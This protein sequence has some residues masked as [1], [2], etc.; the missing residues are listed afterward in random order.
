LAA[1]AAFAGVQGLAA[2]PALA[3]SVQPTIAEELAAPTAVID[4]AQQLADDG[5]LVRAYETLGDLLAGSGVRLTDEERARAMALSESV[6]RGIARLDS[7]EVSLQKAEF[8]LETDDLKAAGHHARAV[9]TSGT[10]SA[11]QTERA[12]DLL[13]DIETRKTQLAPAIRVRLAEALAALEAGE[14]GQAKLDLDAVNRSGVSLSAPDREDLLSA[15]ERVLLAE[16]TRGETFGSPIAAAGVMQPGVVTREGEAAQPE[17]PATEPPATE[18]PATEAQPGE[19]AQP[20]GQEQPDFLQIARQLEAGSTMAD[21][22]IAFGESRWAEAK[23]KYQR[24]LTEFADVLTTDQAAH[25][26]ARG[27]PG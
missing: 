6:G 25:A 23:N 16:V 10:A 21:A 27:H 13:R 1:A 4:R 24:A 7:Y 9:A 3:Q 12:G 18:Q 11:A 8:A 15:Q 19:E 26:R 17:Q 20:E 5:K 2:F 14:Y 22:D